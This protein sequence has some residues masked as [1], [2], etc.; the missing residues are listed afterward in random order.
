MEND[1]T[2][3]NFVAITGASD[4]DAI[5]HL[6]ATN[7]DISAAVELFFAAAG[8]GGEQGDANQGP[9]AGGAGGAPSHPDSGFVDD[10]SLARRLQ[11]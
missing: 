11:K 10:E 3:A 7:F 5:Q 8:G 1:E 2:V 9:A 6:E 4:S